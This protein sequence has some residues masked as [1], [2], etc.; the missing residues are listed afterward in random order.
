MTSPKTKV[1]I[2][3]V[4]GESAGDFGVTD[5]YSNLPDKFV[6]VQVVRAKQERDP[7]TNEWLSEQANFGERDWQYPF[8]VYSAIP[9]RVDLTST[10]MPRNVSKY[11]TDEFVCWF[12]LPSERKSRTVLI[13]NATSAEQALAR[14]RETYPTASVANL[15][16]VPLSEHPLRY[17]EEECLVVRP[18]ADSRR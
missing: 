1:H 13:L 2:G 17:L 18:D 9:G 16:L 14:L 12:W 3:I 7:K 6:D 5:V 4:L 10:S 11:A 15:H 8:L